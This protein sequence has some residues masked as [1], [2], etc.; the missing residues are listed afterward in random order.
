MRLRRTRATSSFTALL[1]DLFG[2]RQRRKPR[3]LSGLAGA[4]RFEERK[5][6]ALTVT[7]IGTPTVG[8][9]NVDLATDLVFTFNENVLKGQGNIYVV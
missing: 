8:A 2:T 7:S 1:S 9:E 3:R 6:L 5:L 4:E